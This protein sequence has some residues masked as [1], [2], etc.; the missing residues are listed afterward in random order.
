MAPTSCCGRWAGGGGIEHLVGTD[1]AAL[2]PVT[3]AEPFADGFGA[4]R[5]PGGSGYDELDGRD[6]A[7]FTDEELTALAL[8]ADPDQPVDAGAR[9]FDPY[10]GRSGI[11]SRCGTCRR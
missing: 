4:T 10:S 3:G 5:W 8:A 6:D 1:G 11:S 2:T 7:G 9:P